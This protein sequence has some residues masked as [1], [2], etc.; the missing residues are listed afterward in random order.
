M[1]HIHQFGQATRRPTAVIWSV[2]HR[3]CAV[4]KAR[5]PLRLKCFAEKHRRK[6]D[7][8]LNAS[9]EHRLLL[10]NS[11]PSFLIF[12]LPPC[13]KSDIVAIFAKLDFLKN[14]EIISLAVWGDYSYCLVNNGRQQNSVYFRRACAEN[15]TFFVSGVTI[16]WQLLLYLFH[17]ANTTLAESKRS[18]D[19]PVFA[20]SLLAS[21][22]LVSWSAVHTDLLIERRIGAILGGQLVLGRRGGCR[23][24]AEY[25]HWPAVTARYQRP[26]IITNIVIGDRRIVTEDLTRDRT[27]PPFVTELS[28]AGVDRNTT[29]EFSCIQEHR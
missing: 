22:R 16:S 29:S 18:P 3:V 6:L 26:T 7:E 8:W 15:A 12:P 14:W 10:G 5:S 24:S 20:L 1:P 28:H 21:G 23:L 9:T 19:L 25:W 13:L 4:T 27:S 17:C 11:V 2:Y